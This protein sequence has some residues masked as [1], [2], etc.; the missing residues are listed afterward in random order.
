VDYYDVLEVE[1]DASQAEIRRAYRAKVKE[2]HPDVSDHPDAADRFRAITRAEEVLGDEAERERYDRLG[3]DGYR[4]VVE[5]GVPEEHVESSTDADGA[6][7]GERG[8]GPTGAGGSGGGAS[9]SGTSAGGSA[10]SSR[11]GGSGGVW[12]ANGPSAGDDNPSQRSYS[13]WSSG[14]GGDGGDDDEAD[15]WWDG[16][17][18]EKDSG[19]VDGTRYG[20]ADSGGG[21][22]NRRAS[23]GPA[24][25]GGGGGGGA[26]AV[27]FGGGTRRRRTKPRSDTGVSEDIWSTDV[28]P[29]AATASRPNVVRETFRSRK[30]VMLAVAMLVTY[31]GFVYFSVTP[32]LPTTLNLVVGAATL[33]VVV[34]TLTEPG[35]ALVVFG[36]W[37]VLSPLVLLFVGTSLL[38]PI[39]L[40]VVG[41]FWVP[42]SLSVV[43]ALALPS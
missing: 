2:H 22:T 42:L 11:S 9:A 34:F 40:A 15:G 37:S 19:S 14:D 5:E 23:T 38:S 8:P 1:R 30:A 41:A 16:D 12:Q 43:V 6:A 28:D 29:A 21:G 35:I 24:A 39:A 13:P 17:P 10:T 7:G 27:D 18:F 25:D 3:H 20:R 31:P 26:R 32:S 36:T 33:A 4:R